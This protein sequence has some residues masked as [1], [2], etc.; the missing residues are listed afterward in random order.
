MKIQL[1][2]FTGCPNVDRARIAVR[3]AVLAEGIEAQVEEIDVESPDAP[4]AMRGWGSPTILVDGSDV[5]GVGRSSGTSCRLY[6]D[7]APSIEQIRAGLATARRQ[8]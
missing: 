1:L 5:T 8:R 7:G 6:A 2:Y 4:E 3:D